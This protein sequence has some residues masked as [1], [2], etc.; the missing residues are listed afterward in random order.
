MSEEPEAQ[1]A[2]A[3]RVIELEDGSVEVHLREPLKEGKR[4]IDVLTFKRMRAKHMNGITIG[5]GSVEW[6]TLMMI[7]S[8]LTGLAPSVLGEL[9]GQDVG[10]VM[11]VVNGFLYR[12]LPTGEP[13]S[14]T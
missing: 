5:A 4:E 6:G 3:A 11:G 8:R 7:A 2:P 1:D 14:S 9:T 13:R 12:F 10:E